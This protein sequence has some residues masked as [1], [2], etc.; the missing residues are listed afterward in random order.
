MV[1]ILNSQSI[2]L[3]KLGL[4]K[5]EAQL[6]LISLETGPATIA[7]LA[8]KSGLKRGTIY[9]FLGE[10]IEKGI[11]EITISGKRKL[12]SG[13]EP[14]KLNKIIERQKAILDNL[15][16]DL[17]MMA[18]GS[19]EKPRIK[20]YEGKDAILSV[21]YEILDLPIGTEVVGFATFEGIHKLYSQKIIDS[22]IKKRAERKIKQKLIVPS[23]EYAQIHS[24]EN[25]KEARET[26]MI[27]KEKFNI[28]NEVNI[29]Q[30]KVV[31]TSLGEENVAVVIE[32][33]QIADSQ[34]AIF[35]LLWYSLKKNN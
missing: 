23:D 4:S 6:Y 2:Q 10:M 18:I 22:Y 9:E 1:Q 25:K 3:Q 21:Y 30:N 27:P 31:I 19:S 13:V 20:F 33:K 16:P 5:K 14:K 11:L 26:I 7:K 28:N 29:Y 17:S 34:R 15:I 8:Q 12:Y 24:A 35:N 32:S